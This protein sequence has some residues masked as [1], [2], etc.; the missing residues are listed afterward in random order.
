MQQ[1]TPWVASGSIGG[2]DP[3]LILKLLD[4][5]TAAFTG[6]VEP[7]VGDV[8]RERNGGIVRPYP[9]PVLIIHT[10]ML[11]LIQVPDG[12]HYPSPSEDCHLTDKIL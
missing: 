11:M 9:Q 7:K 5:A 1:Q 2:G 12:L 6:L 3:Q 8:M 4:E 10:E